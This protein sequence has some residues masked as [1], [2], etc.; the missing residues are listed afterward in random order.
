MVLSFFYVITVNKKNF[1][2]VH[3]KLLWNVTRIFFEWNFVLLST[4]FKWI[5]FFSGSI[6]RST[7]K[8]SIKLKRRIQ[9]ILKLPLGVPPL[10]QS[11][12]EV[13]NTISFHSIDFLFLYLF[14][15][16]YTELRPFSRSVKVGWK[17]KRGV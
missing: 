7:Q 8:K 12:I 6:N 14:S 4:L 1:R 2:I 10:T 11:D 15:T 5:Y 3:F 9:G 13:D 16:Y 17:N